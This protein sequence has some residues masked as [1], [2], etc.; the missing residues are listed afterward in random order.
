MRYLTISFSY[1]SSK[2]RVF[3]S[4]GIF[5]LELATFSRV[6]NHMWIELPG[7]GRSKLTPEKRWKQNWLGKGKSESRCTGSPEWQ[8][9]S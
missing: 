8:W 3:Y 6:Q 5:Q 1:Q 2:S 4:D 9:N 7:Q